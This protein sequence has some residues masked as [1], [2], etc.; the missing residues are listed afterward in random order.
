MTMPVSS[1]VTGIENDAR[2]D[3]ALNAVKSF[4]PLAAPDLAALLA[5]TRDA[6][7]A[8]TSER[9]KTTPGFDGTVRNPQWMG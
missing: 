6:A 9:F 1:V 8:G 5:K 7:L 2:L 4:K 3:Q